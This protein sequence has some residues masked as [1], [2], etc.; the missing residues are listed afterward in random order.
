MSIDLLRLP[1]R[2]SL[3]MREN[4]ALLVFGD[5]SV[6]LAS[7]LAAGGRLS[8]EVAALDI[9]FGLP[10]YSARAPLLMRALTTEKGTALSTLALFA[11]IEDNFVI[12]PR[13]EVFGQTLFGEEPLLFLRDCDL[14]RPVEGWFH[15]PGSGAWV[16]LA[17][18]VLA[19]SRA[20]AG[21]QH[22]RGDDAALHTLEQVFPLDGQMFVEALSLA[23]ARGGKLKALLR[24]Q[25]KS[26]APEIMALCDG[27][28]VL[29][30]ALPVVRVN[31]EAG[32]VTQVAELL[33]AG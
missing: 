10:Y 9:F 19:S 24:A 17:G 27:W 1:V 7:T 23:F 6:L 4:A 11:W 20:S 33:G 25:R 2:G 28:R 32:E 12:E 21:T 16:R 31:A 14:D 8:H 3:V 5:Q 13:A 22:L 26:T 15:A 18:I 30:N 29:C